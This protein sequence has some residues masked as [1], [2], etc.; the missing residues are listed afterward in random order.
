MSIGWDYVSELRPPKGVLFFPQMIYEYGALVE[1]YW[2]GKPEKRG[3][4]P[5]PVPL[6]PPQI[7]RGL[8]RAR[9]RASAVGGRQQTVWAMA[10]PE[11]LLLGKR[12]AANQLLKYIYRILQILVRNYIPKESI[13]SKRLMEQG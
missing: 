4:K 10:R 6:C 9:T 8:S 7:S 13:Q 2:Q 11:I 3:E 12:T 1:W 5:V